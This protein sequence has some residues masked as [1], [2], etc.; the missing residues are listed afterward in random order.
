MPSAASANYFQVDSELAHQAQ[1]E[2]PADGSLA[3]LVVAT[4]TTTAPTVS[5]PA[6]SAVSS[7]TTVTDSPTAPTTP[8][9]PTATAMP[10]TTV[11][12]ATDSVPPTVVGLYDV[13]VTPVLNRPV[14]IVVLGDSTA[15]A[16]GAGLVR[17]AAER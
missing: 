5:A 1:I 7:T 8:T 15:V 12:P 13:V 10:T 17:W 9:A 4:T 2:T 6:S 3:P 14:R 11:V 16:L